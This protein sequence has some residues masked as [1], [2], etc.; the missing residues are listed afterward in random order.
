MNRQS[1]YRWASRIATLLLL[2]ASQTQVGCYGDYVVSTPSGAYVEPAPV[3]VSI[4]PPAP[5]YEA[6]VSCGYGQIWI[7]GYYDWSGGGWGWRPGY[8]QQARSGYTWVAPV[9]RGGTY[10]RGYWGPAGRVYGGGYNGGYRGGYNGGYR[11]APGY[12]PPPAPVYRPAPTYVAP[13]PVY[14]PAPNYVAP[15]PAYRPS[16]GYVPPP[17]PAYRPAPAPTFRP[18]PAAP[19]A[20]VYRPAPTFNR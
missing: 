20:P 9:W 17:A 4:P 10:I 8:C 14:R 1:M 15:A 7:G 12:V 19:A 16:P 6:V 3:S 13:A 11:P 2:A 18:A 5:P